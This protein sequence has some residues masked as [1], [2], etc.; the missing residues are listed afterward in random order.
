MFEHGAEIV[1]ADFHL[2][3]NQDKE[4]QYNGTDYVNDY[5]DELV[6]NEIH[7]GV[8]T[9]HN[10][11]DL[12][13]YKVLKKAAKKKDIF[14]LPGVE[15]SIKQGANAVHTLVVFNP[16]EWIKNGEN[17]IS[18]IIDSFFLGIS[19][20]EN[21][22][23]STN[24][25][26][27]SCIIKMNSM[28][29]DYFL[30]FAHVEQKSGFLKECKGGLIKSLAQ[31]N[32][33]RERAVGFQKVRTR[34]LAQKAKLWMGYEVASVEG[35]D[36]KRIEEI[37]MGTQHTY[38]KIG[39]YSFS[40]IKYALRDFE[41]RIFSEK[42]IIGHG[43]IKSM[44]CLGG[45][46]DGQEFSPSTLLNTFIGIRGSGKS[47]VLEV[48]R[49]ALD[50]DPATDAD[51]KN[52]LVETVLGSGGQVLLT[53]VD[54][55]GKQY[56]VKRILHESVTI[57]DE[58]NTTLPV[59]VGAILNNP[60]YFGQK[61]LALTRAGYEL[62]LL[63]RLVGKDVS[64]TTETVAQIADELCEGI[65]KLLDISDIPER[66]AEITDKN[67]EIEH[68]LK[69]YKER[70]ID[71][72]LR[73]QT[74]CNDDLTKIE[75]VYQKTKKIIDTLE[76]SYSDAD[77]QSISLAD[78]QSEFNQDIFH[79]AKV[80]LDKSIEFLDNI[81]EITKKLRLNLEELD[82]V[83]RK[84]LNRIESLK[85]EFA[86]IKREIND[87]TI[88]LDSFVAYQ[89]T[90]TMNQEEIETL[91]E[92]L[93]DKTKIE[94]KVKELIDKRN[95]SLNQSYQAYCAEIKRINESQDQLNI[96]IEFK[97]NKDIFRNDLQKAF[98]GT[99]ITEIKY[100]EISEQFSDFV[101]ILE[102]YFLMN[103]KK[104]KRI[105]TENVW[106]KVSDK[107]IQN[108]VDYVK[109]YCPDLIRILYHGKLLSK[110]SIGQRASALIL[111]ILTQQDCDVIIID[112]PEDDL[113][114][115]VIYEELIQTIREK[116]KNMQFIFA[117]HNANI[118][119]LG[120]AERIITTIYD[121]D[122]GKIKMDQG[123]I[124]CSSSHKAIVDI[125]EGGEEAFKRRNEIYTSW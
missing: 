113:D 13:E 74:A 38:V 35:S 114:N 97:G 84:L 95:E 20:A 65:K 112:Q 3:T 1:R 39:E 45:K 27:I 107:I 122:T 54:R 7:V 17:H 61:D 89:K 66:I 15:L 29:K 58:E 48:M 60:L 72:K 42:P 6:K 76:N 70:G 43:Y 106:I 11:F 121:G 64:G 37:G 69:I 44:K 99:G 18:K 52:S 115:Q 53:V 32:E 85:E 67:I 19:N 111:F 109:S 63:N 119:V 79:E 102:D 86:Q 24:E 57:I 34:D 41:N 73:K 10:K 28:A 94:S 83:K 96:N 87:D 124:D 2:H 71:S 26:L 40:A 91:R 75:S 62:E 33:F 101:S 116:K 21:E 90:L 12:D 25:D 31:K 23:T 16:D 120:D 118:P 68:K 92:I 80:P 104:L 36:P 93:K 59:A 117:T 103:G 110:H 47:S 100:K 123:T 46:L 30:I 5:I 50:M 51:Y 22:N 105:L 8:I 125:M 55:Y 9:N 14:L 4:F 49:Y 82:A 78:Y 98:K 56:Q 81:K 108:Y 88:D 77:I